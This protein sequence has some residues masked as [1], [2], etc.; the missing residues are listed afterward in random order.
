ME[1]CS[2][3]AEDLVWVALELLGFVAVYEAAD[4]AD[5][6]EVLNVVL[7]LVGS[8]AILMLDG[9]FF[10]DAFWYWWSRYQVA[11]VLEL[12]LVWAGKLHVFY[13]LQIGKI[14][15]RSANLAARQPTHPWDATCDL[16]LIVVLAVFF[17]A[18]FVYYVFLVYTCL[19]IILACC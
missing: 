3:W 8:A 19:I 6:V 11:D 2:W 12:I 15:S 9:V 17:L 10:V 14:M 4:V 5:A 7:T 18:L 16:T 1:V 13:L